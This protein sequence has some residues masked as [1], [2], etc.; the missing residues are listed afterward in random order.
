MKKTQKKEKTKSYLNIVASEPKKN[1]CFLYVNLLSIII[2]Y[3]LN[4]MII[5]ILLRIVLSRLSFF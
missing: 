3:F 5:F 1:P 2:I 4:S